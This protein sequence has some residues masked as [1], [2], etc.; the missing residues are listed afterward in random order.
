[1]VMMKRF[2]V[3]FVLSG[4]LL[5]AADLAG[6]RAVYFLPMS[7]SLDQYLANRL[8]NDHVFQVVS[9][10]ARA[11]AVFTDS[12]GEGFEQRLSELLPEPE[13]TKPEADKKAADDKKPD[14]KKSDDKKAADQRGDL[15][16]MAEAVNKLSRPG[17]SS[18]F[19]RAKGTIFL[20][21]LKSRTVLWSAYLPPKDSTSK[22]LDRTAIAL[23]ER[24]KKDLGKK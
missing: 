4:A 11:D 13:E 10:P 8:T 14:E 22:Q 18:S 3:L 20:V 5:A 23:T 21:D 6:V 1:M 17:A 15:S 19:S 9:D 7:K 16:P 24:I 12:L 2:L